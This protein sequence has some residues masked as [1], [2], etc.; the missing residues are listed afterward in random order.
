MVTRRASS[1]RYA[2]SSCSRVLTAV[3]LS[4]PLGVG[5]A[6]ALP[7]HPPTFLGRGPIATHPHRERDKLRRVSSVRRCALGRRRFSEALEPLFGG[8]RAS[9]RAQRSES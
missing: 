9:P 7:I 5:A 3:L 2:K 6:G 1:G 8:V 4:S